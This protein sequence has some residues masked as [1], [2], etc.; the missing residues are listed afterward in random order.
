MFVPRFRNNEG[1]LNLIRPFV[2][3]SICYKNFNLIPNIQTIRGR[4]VMW[5]FH[6]Y[7]N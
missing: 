3:T 2:C 7:Q 4:A 6:S 5:R 1:T